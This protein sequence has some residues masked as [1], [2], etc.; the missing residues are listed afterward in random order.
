MKTNSLGANDYEI[1]FNDSTMTVDFV[2]KNPNERKIISGSTTIGGTI[3]ANHKVESI[4]DIKNTIK[5][6]FIAFDNQEGI[7]KLMNK[8][9]IVQNPN[10]QENNLNTA[11][12]NP[13]LKK[14]EE[15]TEANKW[16]KIP[17]GIK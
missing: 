1:K 5:Q 3:D 9:S 16:M 12:T 2:S 8:N 15:I 14:M 13:E 17:S 6:I 10:T 11:A 7:N 4:D